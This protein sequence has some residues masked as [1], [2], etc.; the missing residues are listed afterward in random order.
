[1]DLITIQEQIEKAILW[2]EN[3][4]EELATLKA[5]YE[6]KKD[7]RKTQLAICEM[8]IVG[9]PQGETT[10]AA[11]ASNEYQDFLKDLA[12]ARLNYLKKKAEYEAKQ[13]AFDGLRSLN[14]HF[15]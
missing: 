7:F 11:R 9:K 6:Q 2:F 14:R 3:N 15:Q 10:R 13:A 12:Q 1:M 8:Q 5:T 4:H